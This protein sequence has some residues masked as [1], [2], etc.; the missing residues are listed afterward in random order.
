MSVEA[1]ELA[2]IRHRLESAIWIDPGRQSGAPC[3]G[4]TR[5][6]IATVASL[7]DNA[8]RDWYPGVTDEHIAT[9]RWWLTQPGVKQL[10]KER[11]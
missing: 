11:R 7:P 3:F 10:L 8:I 6:P 1:A 2:I 9:L 5:I 4:G